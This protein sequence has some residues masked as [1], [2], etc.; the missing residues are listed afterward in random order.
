MVVSRTQ[1]PITAAYAFTDY[2]AQGQTIAPIIVDIGQPPTGAIT[3]FNVY[4]ALSRVK[5]R[6]SICLLCDFDKCL[7]QQHPNEHLHVEDERL[8]KLDEETERWWKVVE[9][10]CDGK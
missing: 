3:P 10:I 2:H 7:L 5:G 6:D 4:V 8:K 9:K 1:L